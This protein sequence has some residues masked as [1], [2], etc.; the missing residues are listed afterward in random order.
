MEEGKRLSTKFFFQCH[1]CLCVRTQEATKEQ[2][3]VILFFKYIFDSF[4]KQWGFNVLESS[5]FHWGYLK[6]TA[7]ILEEE[8]RE[9]ASGSRMQT[10]A[11]A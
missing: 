9:G 8:N 11:Y 2:V 1:S 3:T 7:T 10:W 4:H 5:R 6:P